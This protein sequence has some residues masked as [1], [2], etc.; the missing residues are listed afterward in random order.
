VFASER[1]KRPISRSNRHHR[2]SPASHPGQ[3]AK[4][5]NRRA[6]CQASNDAARLGA[7]TEKSPRL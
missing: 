3:A 7:P 1:A 6:Q 4:Y 5:H 2:H